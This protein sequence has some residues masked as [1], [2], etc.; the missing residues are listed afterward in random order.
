MQRINARLV[1]LNAEL[2]VGG[3]SASAVALDDGDDDAPSRE[4]EP[5][6]QKERQEVR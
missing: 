6:R 2:D 3:A 5:N 1:E 4:H